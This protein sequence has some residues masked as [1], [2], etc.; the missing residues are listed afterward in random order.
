MPK[1]IVSKEKLIEAGFKSDGFDYME[2]ESMMYSFPENL[3]EKELEVVESY[4]LEF[5]FYDEENN[6]YILTEW[7]SVVK[8]N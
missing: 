4:D 2:L 1:L 3:L 8:E 7:C 6:L 5:D